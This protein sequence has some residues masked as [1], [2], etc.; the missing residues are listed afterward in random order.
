MKCTLEN[1]VEHNQSNLDTIEISDSESDTSGKECDE[2]F[3]N[4]SLCSEKVIEVLFMSCG[5]IC[6]CK[7]CW[8]FRQD[9]RT[10]ERSTGS[11]T[12]CAMI[13]KKYKFV[14]ID[15]P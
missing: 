1:E 7:D 5:H 8:Q 4:C 14:S 9:S 6:V 11:N 10:K 13:V 2:D 3:E 15:C 12:D